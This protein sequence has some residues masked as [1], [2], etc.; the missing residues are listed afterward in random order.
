MRKDFGLAAIAWVGVVLMTI[1]VQGAGLGDS[2][3]A[4]T[5]DIKSAGPLAFAPEGILFF[6]DPQG[7]AI[8]AIDT[9]D[10]G[11]KAPVST[12]NVAGL[13]EKLAAAL[14]TDTKGIRIVDVA[15]NPASGNVY[16]SVARGTGPDAAPVLF[17]VDGAGILSEVS[18]KNVKFAKASLP[19]IPNVGA[20][21]RQEAIT[22][23]AYV[24]G[25]VFVAGQSNEDFS[26]NLRAIPFPFAA[27]DAGTKSVE[28][29]HGA[30]GKFETKSPIRTFV[31]FEIKGEQYLLAG[32]QCTPLV[33]F[34]VKD[35][36]AGSA[37]KGTTIAELGNRNRPLDIIVYKKD[38]KSF[39]LIANNSRG[40][41]KVTTEAID[42]I[43][44]IETRISD[45]AGL[46]YETVSDL[47]GVVQLDKLN[48]QS[49][50][51]LVDINGKQDLKTVALP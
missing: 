29:Y 12:V 43:P 39:I 22:D 10:A 13:N 34:P 32:Y 16:L 19:S 18:L 23:L 40:V 42:S 45:K 44:G 4:G 36:M 46:S 2:L 48:D 20:T 1:S 15:V 17:K 27:A 3:K 51:V 41:M 21:Q 8:F 7:A 30:H 47:Q 31:P 9:S 24:S 38:G 50:V 49:A 37:L 25:R 33:K 5:P 14:G 11:G 35:L 6:S 28:I 26:S